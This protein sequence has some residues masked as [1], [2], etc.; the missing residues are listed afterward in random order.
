MIDELNTEI[1]GIVLRTSDGGKMAN[2]KD[3]Q[4]GVVVATSDGF[5]RGG[6]TEFE[7]PPLSSILK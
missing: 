2:Y 6:S 3:R 1:T 4:R 5:M 7:P